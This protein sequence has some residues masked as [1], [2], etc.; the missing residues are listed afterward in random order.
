M[1]S[2]TQKVNE[3]LTKFK[4]GKLDDFDDFFHLTFS[5]VKMAAYANLGDKSFTDDVVS[6]TYERVLKSINI[7]DES[8]SGL[9][10][11]LTIAKHV[12]FAYDKKRAASAEVSLESLPSDV[13]PL[14]C[15]DRSGESD[16]AY[17]LEKALETLEPRER[18][19]FEL[20]V[21]QDMR[22]EDAAAKL[23]VSIS[24]VN[25]RVKGA[26]KKI[27]TYLRKIRK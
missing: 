23:E 16:D 22:I 17:E 3:Y 8:K 25:Y 15:E 24:T 2:L 12:A 1:A 11:I 5:A 10:W 19:A 13:A 27:K 14:V 18:A 6:E 7:F 9:G 20:Y 26:A 21:I 4:S